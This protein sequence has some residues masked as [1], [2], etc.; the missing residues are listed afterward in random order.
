MS[1]DGKSVWKTIA[2]KLFLDF[3]AYSNLS[4][5]DFHPSVD[6]KEFLDGKITSI[7]TLNKPVVLVGRD[8]I[9]QVTLQLEGTIAY[10]VD[11]VVTLLRQK[12]IGEI[13]QT[14]II[15]Q[16]RQLDKFREHSIT[17]SWNL[18]VPLNL[19]VTYANELRPMYSVRYF[20]KVS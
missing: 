8:T 10:Q 16:Q 3:R 4:S 18:D 20:L 11:V 6:F 19:P 12:Q 13:V 5:M 2:K 7:F 15:S 14:E 1:T 17:L 9:L